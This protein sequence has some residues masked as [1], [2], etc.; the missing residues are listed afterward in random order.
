MWSLGLSIYTTTLLIVTLKL[1]IHTPRYTLYHIVSLFLFFLVYTA[2][3]YFN[4]VSS[5]LS[6]EWTNIKAQ[7]A[8]IFASPSLWFFI[9]LGPI[10][11]CLPD[12]TIQI[13]FNQK[14]PKDFHIMQ[15]MEHGWRKNNYISHHQDYVDQISDFTYE[16]VVEED[17]INLIENE[18]P[19]SQTIFIENLQ[20]G[21][22][23]EIDDISSSNLYNAS[24]RPEW[25][26]NLKHDEVENYNSNHPLSNKDVNI[27]NNFSIPIQI[28]KKDGR[29]KFNREFF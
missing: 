13:F 26:E 28:Q 12:T 2:T 11:A 17:G 8:F 23:I 29:V 24:D 22:N 20:E 14:S 9:A 19:S 27:E 4:S 1:A 25:T 10:A 7:A 21:G 5:K 18:I 6:L 16:Q 3:L 15:E